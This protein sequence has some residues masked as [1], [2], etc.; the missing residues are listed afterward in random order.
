MSNELT[1]KATN[2]NRLISVV[3]YESYQEVDKQATS[4]RQADDKQATTNKNEKNNKKEKELNNIGF[5]DEDLWKDFLLMRVKMKKP[6]TD[7]AKERM[8]KKLTKLN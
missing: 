3:N 8:I 2:K 4:K 7:L 1:S 6:M 5:L